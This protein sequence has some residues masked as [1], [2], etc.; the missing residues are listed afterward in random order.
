M[1]EFLSIPENPDLSGRMLK[2]YRLLRHLGS[3]AMA[4]VYLAEQQ[5]LSRHVAV[6]VLRP[7]KA[8]NQTAVKR[9]DQEARAAASL[10]HG[11]IVQIHEVG[12]VDGIHYIVQEYVAGLSLKEWLLERGTLDA[13]AALSV[14]KQV[15]AA[16]SK[17][18]QQGIIHR[19]IKPENL[20][21]T[22]AGEVKVA[23]FGL[24]RVANAPENL[25]LTQ[26]GT[27]LGTPLYMSPEQVEGLTLD[28]R[29]DL[30]SLGATIYHLLS[31]YP[32]FSGET[33]LAV[34][35]AHVKQQPTSLAT[36]R[37]DLPAGLVAI[38]DRLLS[39]D[40]L[41]RPSGPAELIRDVDFVVS[42]SGQLKKDP[43]S[44]RIDPQTST[45]VAQDA[46]RNA[47]LLLT[48][49]SAAQETQIRT[50][51]LK[52]DQELSR[53]RT[54]VETSRRWWLGTAA[55][56]LAGIAGGILLG[57]SRPR[58]SLFGRGPR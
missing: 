55:A 33:R 23:D 40:P 37:Q 18:Q 32:P 53:E 57:R 46:P 58:R 47:E 28:S 30:Y 45:D 17:A 29:S 39:K 12:F 25:S 20:L 49:T 54:F 2:D 24:A 27:T 43:L 19:D 5:S 3:G 13:S 38:V 50:A 34:A 22:P 48:G 52:L 6:K 51:T 16:L 44:W 8:L 14:L 41:R 15:A 56:A 4:D 9:F 35:L 42:A 36:I 10:V 1:Q 21:I 7:E 31:G 11:N 26:D